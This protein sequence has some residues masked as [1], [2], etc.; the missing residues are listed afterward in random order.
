MAQAGSMDFP[1]A[2]VQP[3]ELEKPAAT[4]LPESDEPISDSTSSD[5]REDVSAKIQELTSYALQFLSNATNETLG[6]CLVG[7][8][9]ITY[10]V[11]GRVGLV[12]IG[13]FGGVVLHATW[14][15]NNQSQT[16][17]T[18]RAL[19][20]AKKRERGLDVIERVLGWRGRR[21]EGAPEN[22]P[23]QDQDSMQPVSSEN[24]SDFQPAVR[25]ALRSL[26]DAVIRDYVKYKTPAGITEEGC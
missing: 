13:V 4:K 2:L 22:D 12:L 26:T 15:E 23:L 16:D 6:A 8:G 14:E 24:Y 9:A 7:L 20:V 10:L 25:A 19:E 11:L 17:E 21:N 5:I 18:I 3:P 1:Q